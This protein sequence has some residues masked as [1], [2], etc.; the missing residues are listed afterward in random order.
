MDVLKPFKNKENRTVRLITLFGSLAVIIA[1]IVV[2]AIYGKELLAFVKDTKGFRNW[3]DS[4]GGWAECVFVLIRAFQ[5]VIKIVPAEPLEI[6]SGYAF[7]TFWGTV[8]CMA[9]T[10]LGSAV[11]I[12]LTKIFGKKLVL[13]FVSQEKIDSFK[14]LND[15]KRLTV[16]L[17]LIYLIPGTPKDVITFLIGLTKMKLW[18]FLLVTGIARIPSIITSTIVGSALG[19]NKLKF[20]IIIYVLTVVISALALFIYKFVEK[21]KDER[22]AAAEA[23][24]QE[25]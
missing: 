21:K 3:L 17:F 15:Q 12:L 24:E 25:A 7:G 11:I 9:G 23:E 19:E 13:S 6:G 2:Y 22:K 18:V 5:T 20:A 10:E 4:F 16:T 1:F 8:W 14:F